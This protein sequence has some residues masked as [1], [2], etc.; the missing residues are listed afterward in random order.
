MTEKS[1]T[2]E[3]CKPLEIDIA[4]PRKQQQQPDTE[5]KAAKGFIRA[6]NGRAA[7]SLCFGAQTWQGSQRP[8]SRVCSSPSWVPTAPRCMSG[9]SVPSAG[10]HDADHMGAHWAA[11]MQCTH[12]IL[13]AMCR[14]CQANPKGCHS[15]LFCS[16]FSH[17]PSVHPSPIAEPFILSTPVHSLHRGV[18]HHFKTESG[19]GNKK[20][21]RYRLS[22]CN[23]TE[24]FQNHFIIVF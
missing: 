10:K 7:A 13:H 3:P 16:L 20:K 9:I 24:P 5:N 1:L 17:Q 23:S 11:L 19:L 14:L 21:L 4:R 12:T 2:T 15:H 22:L 6:D 18:T 8:P